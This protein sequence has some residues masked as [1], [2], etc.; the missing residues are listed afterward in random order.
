MENL[1][2]YECGDCEHNAGDDGDGCKCDLTG[3]AIELCSKACKR[4]KL[5]EG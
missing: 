4:F 3:K 2:R 1:N 5:Y